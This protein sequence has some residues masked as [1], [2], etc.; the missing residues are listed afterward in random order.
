MAYLYE[1]KGRTVTQKEMTD[2][3]V[4]NHQT[5]HSIVW[6]LGNNRLIE[7][8]HLR[9][10]KWQVSWSLSEK[11]FNLLEQYIDNIYVVMDDINHQIMLELD[12]SEEPIFS[13]VLAKI[14][15]DF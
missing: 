11:G 2:T 12:E 15:H 6:R 1:F 9:S 3:L 10:D 14:I 4:L 5:I 13:E 8:W 7:V